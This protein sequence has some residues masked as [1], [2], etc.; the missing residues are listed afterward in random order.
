MNEIT[1]A[2]RG[3]YWQQVLSEGVDYWCPITN[4]TSSYNYFQFK[5]CSIL[6]SIYSFSVYKSYNYFQ[7]KFGSFLSSIYSFSVYK[8]SNYFQFKFSSI[9]SFSV[10]TSSN[11]FQ[12]KFSLTLSLIYNFNEATAIISFSTMRLNAAKKS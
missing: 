8:S 11:Y 12:F 6:S 7:F 1:L 10:Y 2:W 4:T 9:Y 3:S 5:F